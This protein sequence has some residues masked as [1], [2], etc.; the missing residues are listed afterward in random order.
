MKRSALIAAIVERAPQLTY[1]DT[2]AAVHV[3]RMTDGLS[4]TLPFSR[5]RRSAN[6]VMRQ[7][8]RLALPR[9]AG[10]CPRMDR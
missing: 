5:A 7:S 1:A 3:M 4:D 8:P 10:A 9:L 2:E 6:S